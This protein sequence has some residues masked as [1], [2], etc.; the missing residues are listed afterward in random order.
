MLP[1]KV[2]LNIHCKCLQYSKIYWF[3]ILNAILCNLKY[4]LNIIVKT[5]FGILK[6]CGHQNFF[7]YKSIHCGGA[8][9]HTCTKGVSPPFEPRF[10]RPVGHVVGWQVSLAFYFTCINL[11]LSKVWSYGTSQPLFPSVFYNTAILLV[12]HFFLALLTAEQ[13]SLECDAMYSCVKSPSPPF[14]NPKS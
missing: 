1:Q 14:T 8:T 12:L 3:F 6:V 9:P 11:P 10:A 13:N 2:Q 7:V 5:S 4:L